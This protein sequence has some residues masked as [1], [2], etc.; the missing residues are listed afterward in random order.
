MPRKGVPYGG[1]ICSLKERIAE[2]FDL[3]G[4][5][6]HSINGVQG[7]GQGNVKLKSGDPAVVI[8]GDAAQNEIEIALDKSKLP[9]A[10][11]SSV[12]GKTGAVVLNAGDIPT[13]GNSDVQTDIDVGKAGLKNCIVNI[14]AEREARQNADAALQTNINAAQ[15]SIPEMSTTPDPYKGVKR[16]AQGR[17]FAADP[18]AGATDKTLVT[19][20]WVSQTGNGAPNNLVHRS[21]NERIDNVK[22][23]QEIKTTNVFRSNL[24]QIGNNNKWIK[25]C[26]CS[27]NIAYNHIFIVTSAL[28][29][30]PGFGILHVENDYSGVPKIYWAV[31]KYNNSS[32]SDLRNADCVAMT[33]NAGDDY[34]S[35]FVKGEYSLR[36]MAVASF[37][38]YITYDDVVMTGTIEEYDD[39]SS[40][41]S[42]YYSQ[43]YPF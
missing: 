37:K 10:A 7:D 13:H 17:A 20:N 3:V 42:V 8:T 16:D 39:L 35:I 15:A 33:K 36:L 41:D 34:Y 12:N 18:A 14:I 40:F 2:L 11:V 22:D 29:G 24:I 5:K 38:A 28:G 26:T 27:A 23:Y 4:E 43:D 6:L 32:N 9:S 25:V 30:F 31:R 19:A 1:G 21:G